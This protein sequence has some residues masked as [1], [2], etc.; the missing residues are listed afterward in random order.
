MTTKYAKIAAAELIQEGGVLV[1]STALDGSNGENVNQDIDIALTWETYLVVLDK[2]DYLKRDGYYMKQHRNYYEKSKLTLR[3]GVESIT[4]RDGTKLDLLF[5]D[6]DKL[7]SVQKAI[8]M[9]S[10]EAD[11]FLKNKERRVRIFEML[12]SSLYKYK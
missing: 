5:Y 11:L 10:K 4:F 3:N 7:P 6:E 8:N 9:M 12:V 2:S 1:G